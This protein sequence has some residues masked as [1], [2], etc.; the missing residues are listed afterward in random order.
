MNKQ[1]VH[2]N[3]DNLAEYLLLNAIKSKAHQTKFPFTEYSNQK[4]IKTLEIKEIIVKRS[5]IIGK[6][7]KAKKGGSELIPKTFTWI[8]S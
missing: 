6:P 7:I 2:D 4:I 3:S 1:I 5:D 8:Y